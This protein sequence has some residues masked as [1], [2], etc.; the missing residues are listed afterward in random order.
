MCIMKPTANM[1]AAEI[2]FIFY[3]GDKQKSAAHLHV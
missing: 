2:R 1:K 3:F